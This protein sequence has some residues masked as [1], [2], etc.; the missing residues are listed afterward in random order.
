MA[1]FDL[2]SSIKVI[3]PEKIYILSDSFTNRKDFIELQIT[4]FVTSLWCL[5]MKNFIFVLSLSKS[6]RSVLK[7]SLLLKFIHTY[8][9]LSMT[10]AERAYTQCFA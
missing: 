3:S 10:A 8:L 5:M 2:A 7:Y 4:I 6:I 9:K 1:T